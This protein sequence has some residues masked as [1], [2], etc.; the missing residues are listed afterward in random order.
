MAHVE[1]SPQHRIQLPFNTAFNCIKISTEH[2]IC[3]I[4][5]ETA[6]SSSKSY[7][8]IGHRGA[9]PRMPSSV[10]DVQVTLTLG[11][12]GYLSFEYAAITI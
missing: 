3:N 2:G 7:R 10:L 6:T 4:I 9:Y 1:P 8:G 11:S 5:I 12:I